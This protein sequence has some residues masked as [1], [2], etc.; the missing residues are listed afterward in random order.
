[1][2]RI[3]ALLTKELSLEFRTRYPF[4]SLVSFLLSLTYIGYLSFQTDLTVETWN[5]VFWIITLVT[6]TTAVGKSFIQ[7]ND[8]SYYYYFLV[9]PTELLISKMIYN[10]TFV[11]LLTTLTFLAMQL[12]FP[13]RI[14]DLTSFAMNGFLVAIG[15][16]AAFTLISSIASSADP[17]SNTMA[18]L[19]FPIAIPVL[20]LGVTISRK[21]LLGQNFDNVRGSL[22]SLISVDVIIIALIFVLFP[23]SWKK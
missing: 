4:L 21:L 17:K 20:L 8:R 13:L 6:I 22:T 16:S 19:G 1:M 11:V 14:P 3:F 2:N 18:V 23:F 7:E 5:A 12:F 9:R 15:L 10:L